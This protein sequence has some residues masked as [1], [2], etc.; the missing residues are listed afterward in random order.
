M[1]SQQDKTVL[2]LDYTP[3]YDQCRR[4]ASQVRSEF[5]ARALKIM[6]RKCRKSLGEISCRPRVGAHQ[7]SVNT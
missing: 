5:L 1:I 4:N 7:R 3:R 6:F 2:R